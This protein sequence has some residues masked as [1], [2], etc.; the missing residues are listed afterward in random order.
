MFRRCVLSMATILWLL[1]CG[2]TQKT[3][4]TVAEDNG[5]PNVAAASDAKAAQETDKKAAEARTFCELEVKKS[6]SKPFELLSKK[7]VAACLLALRPEIN[8][9][10]AKSVERDIILKI[11]IGS[12]GK[13]VGAFPVGDGADS[14][15]ASCVTKIV[16]P[17]VFPRFSSR[18]QQVIEKYPF[19]LQP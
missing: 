11:I 19:H 10:C 12:D 15:E 8:A 7:Q 13:V 2:S 17:A 5:S 1:G 4:S 3:T 6:G 16:R 18:E 9:Q 14:E